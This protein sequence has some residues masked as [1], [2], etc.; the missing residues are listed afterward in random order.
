[1]E[2]AVTKTT[3]RKR[4]PEGGTQAAKPWGSNSEYGVLR[5]VLL[6]PPD[7]LRLL[8]TS[9]LSRK[10]LREGMKVDERLA[11]DQYAQMV[12]AYRD[13]GVT[14]HTLEPDPHLPYQVF[15]RDSSVMTPFGAIVTQ[16]FQP[17][18]RGEY[19]PVLDFYTRMEIPIYDKITAGSLEGGD[20]MILEP[21]VALCGWSDDRTQQAAAQQVQQWLELEGFDVKLVAI[22]PFYV[23]L[24]LMI[25]AL[26]EK[27]VAACLEI[28]DPRVVDWLTGKGFKFVS[29]PFAETMNLG[30]NVTALG[31]DRVLLPRD[32]KVLKEKCKALG[33]QVYDPDVSMFT[34]CG[35]GIH[36][37]CQP[38]QRD[39][40]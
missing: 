29:V 1:M 40:V 34:M 30:C 13:A 35:G 17:W 16:M 19:G 33:L 15:V 39:P 14:V 32:S 28:L 12:G 20:L 9:S 27:L 5:S 26:A 23:H 10:S 18:R 21:G 11:R 38:L 7:N 6:C 24:D 3:L 31:Q 25:V 4:N 37:M 36:C 22:D 8:P 2:D